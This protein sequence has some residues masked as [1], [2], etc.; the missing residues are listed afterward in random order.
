MNSLA[1]KAAVITPGVE[2][3]GIDTSDPNFVTE[4]IEAMAAAALYLCSCAPSEYTGQSGVSLDLLK[5]LNI[6]Y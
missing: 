6:D 2:A 5:T 3:L 4:P 1:P